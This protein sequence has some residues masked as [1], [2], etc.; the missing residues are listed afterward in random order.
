M[1]RFLRRLF[2]VGL[3]LFVLLALGLFFALGRVLSGAVETAGTKAL[4]VPV[5][6]A[7]T[8]VALLDGA[9]ALDGLVVANP[10]GFQAASFLELDHAATRVELGSLS[11]DQ[12]EIARVEVS[13]VRLELEGTPQGT[14]FGKI[15]EALEKLKGKETPGEPKPEPTPEGSAKSIKIGELV[16]KDI[17]LHTRFT[18]DLTGSQEASLTLPELK[19]QNLGGK[20][21]A[22][23]TEIVGE[24]VSAL[25][26]ASLEAGGKSIPLDARKLLEDGLGKVQVQALDKVRGELDRSLEKVDKAVDKALDKLFK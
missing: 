15:L 12:I 9:L 26:E 22:P 16:L 2:L 17:A 19:L 4:G 6:L 14:N 3:V 20:D 1:F 7:G 21:G 13:G 8:D 23:L 25:L 5:T 10:A 18:S 11:S 24:V